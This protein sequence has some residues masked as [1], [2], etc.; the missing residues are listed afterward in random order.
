MKTSLSSN[1][2][3]SQA[4]FSLM[5]IM[6]GMVLGLLGTIV[7]FQ[8]FSVSESIK[9]TTTSGGEAQQNGVAG[10]FILQR[11][12]KAAGYG[13][14]SNDISPTP[15]QIS[16]G[17]GGTPDTITVSYRQNWDYGPF[18]PSNL[19]FVSAVPPALTFETYSINNNAQLLKVSVPPAADDGILVDGVAQLKA[20]YGTDADLDGIVSNSEW[21]TT[22][23]LNPMRVLAI[24]LALVA[25][26]AQPEKAIPG[27]G[28]NTTTAS[29]VWIGGVIDL[30]GNAG[31]ALGDQWQCYRY[32]TFEVTV[33]L[34][35]LIWR[36]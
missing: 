28:C 16:V 9:R 21:V 7:I 10:M 15:V 6:V 26:S 14:N 30:S 33:P 23:P 17:G 24:R 19:T 11:A 35:N 5:D 36:P 25:R 22:A 32:K 4:G 2:R 31:L 1:P 8:V 29:P 27:I 13:I 18:A 12:L 20:Q 34:R 3:N